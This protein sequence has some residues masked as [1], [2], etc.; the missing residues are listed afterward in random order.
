MT[1]HENVGKGR[2]A[3]MAARRRRR[4]SDQ[5]PQCGGLYSSTMVRC[6]LHSPVV[7]IGGENASK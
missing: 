5:A 4:R 2:E 7:Y 1:S 3:T 6:P